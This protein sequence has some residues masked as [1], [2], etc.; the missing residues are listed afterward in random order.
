MYRV[1]R[2]LLFTMCPETAHHAALAALRAGVL[3]AHK[4]HPSARLKQTLWGYD[5]AH[6][7]GLAAGFDKNAEVID[8]VAAQGM[9]FIECGTVTPRAQE[10]NPKPRIFRVPEQEA[11]INR[12]G[13][14]NKGLDIF[15]RNVRA[16]KTHAIVGGNIGKNKDSGDAVA[17]YVTCLQAVYPYVDYVTVNISSPNTPGLRDLQAEE[18]LNLLINA[19]HAERA[20]LMQSGHKQ[21]PILVKIAPD[22]EADALAMIAQTAMR[23]T[24]DGLIVSNTT[25]TRPGIA[26]KPEWQTGGLSGKPLM[27]LATRTLASIA[28]ITKGTIPLIG[29]GGVASA[30]DAY[31]KI[32]HGASLVQVYTALIYQGFALVPRIV[33]GLDR[34][35][36]R[37]GFAT[38][39]DAIGKKL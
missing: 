21:K 26:A 24:L 27:P 17:D 37:D 16:R 1:F 6:P 20:S 13:F 18:A 10:G 3:P 15:V 5:F 33:E 4:P 11:V 31:E 22:L 28:R 12:L 32:L 19:L 35:M 7:L 30:E 39:G 8:G 23:H 29:V 25:I 34:L 9:A 14:N 38:I 36:A 2:P